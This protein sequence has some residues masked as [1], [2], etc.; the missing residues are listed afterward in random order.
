[1]KECIYDLIPVITTIINLSI[2]Q[3]IVPDSFKH[4]TVHPLLKKPGLDP[5]ELKNFRPVS[6]LSF[7]SKIL[8]KVVQKQ[9]LSHLVDNK[10]LE[11]QQSAYRKG[12]SV[13]TAV[14]GVVQALLLKADEGF[15]SLM[16]L[17]DLSAAFD[18][19][20]HSILLKRL[21]VTFGIRGT[22]LTWFKSYLHNRHQCVVIDGSMSQY[23]K[24]LYGVPQ[25]SVL[26]PILFS[27]YSQPL[28]EILERY[29]CQY[30][31]YA[32]DTE[33]SCSGPPDNF[34][35]SVEI[36][37]NCVQDVMGW[38]ASNKLKLNPDKTEAIPIGCLKHLGLVGSDNAVMGGSAVPYQETVRYLGVT[39]DRSLSMEQH[40]SNVSR[41]CYYDIRRISSIRPYLTQQAA[42]SLMSALVLSRLDYCNSLFAGLDQHQIDR[43]QRIQNHAARVVTKKKM[44]DHATPLLRELHWLPVKSRCR[45]KIATLAYR[46]FEGTLPQYLSDYLVT[47]KCARPVRSSTIKRLE[48]PKKPKLKTIG[49]RTFHQIAPTVWNSLPA[50]LKCLPSLSAFRSGLKTFLFTEYF[51]R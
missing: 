51:E 16:A 20:D 37:Q 14:L 47:R 4:A 17:L 34:S 48:P 27:L 12:H 13:E 43:L 35:S 44:R 22:V 1:M 10:L 32:D 8:E 41:S 24:L 5:N 2:S 15:L 18:T 46:H 3:G 39:I 29:Q 25:G 50:D 6:N 9:L 26:G 30:H 7:V 40:I 45:F 42:A 28:T 23:N 49:G 21:D 19:L 33:V 31:K 11:V 38:M 36:V